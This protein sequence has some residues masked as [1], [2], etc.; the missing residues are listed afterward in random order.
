VTEFIIPAEAP[1]LNQL[2]ER[3]MDRIAR[4]VILTL[5][6]K[7]VHG[8]LTLAENGH[9]HDFGEKSNR[10]SLQATI[11]V[12]H[13]QLYTRLLFGGS[14]GAAEAYM[15]GFWSADDLTTVMRILALNQKAFEDMEKGLARLTAPFN[16][17]YHFVRKNTRVGSRKNIL[18]HYDLGN[19]FYALFLDET[20]T[21]S[22]GIFEQDGSTLKEASEAKYDRICRKL[23]LAA[24]DRVVEIGTGWG[25]FAVH[26]AQNYG[27]QVT[28]TTIS[29][30]QHQFA[31]NRIKAAGLEDRIILLKKDYRD[32]SGEFD[33]L[34]SIEMIEAVGHQYLTTFFRTCSRL[35][36][37]NGM[38]ALQAIT[39]GDQIFDR[40]KRS[41]DF[42]KRYIFPGSCIPSITS[43]SKALAK[44]TDLRLVH[45]EDI[46][47]HYVR[48][49][50]E[51]RRQF[52]ANIEKVRALGFSEPF[53]RMWEYYLCYCEGGFA[54]RYI[55]DVQMLFVKPLCRKGTLPV[56]QT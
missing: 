52:F 45:L 8:G 49:L 29:D 28:T 47:P 25:G 51:W 50:G 56:A 46:T 16:R 54:E 24:G 34:V 3:R 38:M 40:H 41:V 39:I 2:K 9:R 30:Q 32:L 6:E 7:L 35:L 36:K 43:I 18:A 10:V 27:V 20:M 33:K 19:D 26:A 21:Y 15:E 44:A 12:H 55:G 48:T 4:R 23:Q 37:D 53:V 11:F 42:I 31:Q 1:D 14:I 17:F 22:C 5:F 13:P